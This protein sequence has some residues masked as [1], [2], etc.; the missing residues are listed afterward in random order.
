MKPENKQILDLVVEGT[1]MMVSA[2]GGVAM[3]ALM[4][5]GTG[6]LAYL[7]GMDV[8][9]RVYAAV[10]KA[11]AKGSG[12]TAVFLVSEA[13]TVAGDAPELNCP[14]S[15]HPDRREVVMVAWTTVEGETGLVAYDIL[16]TEG[17]VS[18]GTD[19]KEMPSAF[20]FFL[21]G[22]FAPPASA[23]N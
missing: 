18:L 4:Y 16:R 7:P 19:A 1:R 17:G 8:D 13:W 12:S 14:P 9:K 10:I 11:A 5:D 21:D 2:Y 23:L 15:E 20:N 22:V 6:N 3:H